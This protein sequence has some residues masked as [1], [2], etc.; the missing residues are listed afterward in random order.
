[1]TKHP[2]LPGTKW[3]PGCG[4]FGA[5]ARKSQANQDKLVTLFCTKGNELEC[6]WSGVIQV[7]MVARV[8]F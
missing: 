1:M 3:V 2:S 7:E 8:S 6:G 5:K 4:T